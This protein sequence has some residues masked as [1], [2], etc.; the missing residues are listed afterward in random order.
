MKKR[1]KAIIQESL[2]SQTFIMV[3]KISCL[4]IYTAFEIDLDSIF[5]TI[6]TSCIKERGKVVRL[7]VMSAIGETLCY[8]C[9]VTIPEYRCVPCGCFECCK[10]CAMKMATGIKSS[11]FLF[12]AIHESLILGPKKYFPSKDLFGIFNF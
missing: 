12:I 10:K 7:V 9:K 8:I 6:R 2:M 1:K 5:A 4:H 11:P 3:Y